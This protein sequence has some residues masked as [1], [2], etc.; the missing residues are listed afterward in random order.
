MKLGNDFTEDADSDSTQGEESEKTSKEEEEKT[1]AGTDDSEKQEETEEESTDE[2]EESEDEESEDD[3]QKVLDG[4]LEAEKNLDGSTE[5]V[6]IK[7]AAA[8]Q[9][10]IDKRRGRR[11]KRDLV[12][13]IDSK[14]PENTEEI[15][16]L[17]DID[18]DTLLVLDRFTKAK[19][20]VPK[21]ELARMTYQEK[22]TSAESA[23]YD[24]HPEYLPENDPDDVLYNAIKQELSYFTTPS[25]YKMIPK[26]FAKA[27]SEVAKMYPDKFKGKSTAGSDTQISKSVRIKTQQLG[28]KSGGSSGKSNDSDSKPSFSDAQIRALEDGG[29]SQED[30]KRLTQ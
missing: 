26:L 5:D 1:S 19:G 30:I 17:S 16:D 24:A 29:W 23:F 20:L 9:R 4:L 10:I 3:K 13:K 12:E 21:S 25:D 8:K 2:Q 15:D 27:H 22:H 6:D 11:E 14:F 18:P 7:I 28:S